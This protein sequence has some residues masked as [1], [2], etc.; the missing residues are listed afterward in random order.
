MRASPVLF[1]TL[2]NENYLRRI[3]SILMS[4]MV[5]DYD[6]LIILKELKYLF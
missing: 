6:I 1:I 4:W 3:N 5:G 2:N